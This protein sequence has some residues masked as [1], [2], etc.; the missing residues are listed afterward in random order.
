[1][2]DHYYGYNWDTVYDALKTLAEG[3]TDATGVDEFKQVEAGKPDNISLYPGDTILIAL[4]KI[5]KI[6]RAMGGKGKVAH[7]KGYFLVYVDGRDEVA[8]RRA[9]YLWDRL[10]SAVNSNTTLLSNCKCTVDYEN[11]GGFRE[12]DKNMGATNTPDLCAGSVL[13]V[14]IQKGMERI[15]LS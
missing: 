8:Q 9:S 13:I 10:Q 6:T 3:I 2:T 14:D 12:N 15:E 1:M 5:N 7:I 11:P 4:G